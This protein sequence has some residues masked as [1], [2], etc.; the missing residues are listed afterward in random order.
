LRG[1]RTEEH[2]HRETARNEEFANRFRVQ[3]DQLSKFHSYS[4]LYPSFPS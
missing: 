2:R 3:L 4:S 1:S